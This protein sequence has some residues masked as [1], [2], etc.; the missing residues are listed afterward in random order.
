MSTGALQPTTAMPDHCRLRISCLIDGAVAFDIV[1]AAISAAIQ[2]RVVGIRNTE[3]V[4]HDEFD[5][6]AAPAS[7][8][9]G[10]VL[11]RD[12]V[13]STVSNPDRRGFLLLFSRFFHIVLGQVP[14]LDN[15]ADLRDILRIGRIAAILN[16]LHSL[17]IIGATLKS[18][19]P[20][21][22]AIHRAKQVCAVICN[23]ILHAGILAEIRCDGIE[24]SGSIILLCLL[25]VDG[26]AIPRT[27]GPR[28]PGEGFLH[29][30]AVIGILSQLGAA[31]SGFQNKLRQRYRCKNA[32]LLLIGSKESAD[33]LHCIRFR[34]SLQRRRLQA[35]GFDLGFCFLLGASAKLGS[36]LLGQI[37]HPRIHPVSRAGLIGKPPV[38]RQDH[39]IAL[40]AVI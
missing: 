24:P 32:T 18:C 36:Y 12:V 1:V 4:H 20:L 15:T 39:L 5:L 31:V 35:A 27:P 13:N 23:R 21:L 29:A 14:A 33:L 34:E 10:K 30:K 9:L 6:I 11:L 19:I 37:S 25:R 16:V 17:L 3:I 38:H 40:R 8:H 2:I 22:A 7:R 28:I 26:L